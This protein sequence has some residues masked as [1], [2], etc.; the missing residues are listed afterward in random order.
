MKHASKPELV[1]EADSWDEMTFL[2]KVKLASEE[3]LKRSVI[4]L[5]GRE[6]SVY[7]VAPAVAQVM[8]ILKD[9]DGT[10]LD[11]TLRGRS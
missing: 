9:V 3:K 5:L 6:E 1:T 10:E 2:H 7:Y 8:R 4:I 11:N